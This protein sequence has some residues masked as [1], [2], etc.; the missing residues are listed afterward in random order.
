MRLTLRSVDS[1]CGR[2]FT[3][4][5]SPSWQS[6]TISSAPEMVRTLPSGVPS[7]FETAVKVNLAQDGILA[8]FRT[9]NGFNDAGEHVSRTGGVRLN[10]V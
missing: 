7:S 4:M 6:P 1:L 10:S 9:P 8:G 5:L 3:E 2:P